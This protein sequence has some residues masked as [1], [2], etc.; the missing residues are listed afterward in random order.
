MMA[1]LRSPEREWHVDNV[2]P[3]TRRERDCHERRDGATTDET[4]NGHPRIQPHPTLRGWWVCAVAGSRSIA[5]GDSPA[6]AFKGWDEMG[7]PA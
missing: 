4:R 5:V 2:G 3:E 6:H 7:R 1:H